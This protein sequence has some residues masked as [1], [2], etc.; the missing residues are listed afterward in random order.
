M[1]KFLLPVAVLMLAA[2]ISASFSGGTLEG[3]TVQ[4]VK[5]LMDLFQ[6]NCELNAINRAPSEEFGV[7]VAEAGKKRGFTTSTCKSIQR[8]IQ[9]RI[10]ETNQEG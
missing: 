1:K 9:K 3:N 10:E 7:S 8:I 5:G 6:E 2:L 4:E